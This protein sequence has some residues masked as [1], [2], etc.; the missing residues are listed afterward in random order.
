MFW[1]YTIQLWDWKSKK[2]LLLSL[3][4]FSVSA[5]NDQMIPESSFVQLLKVPVAMF[6]LLIES[7][8]YKHLHPTD[9]A[10]ILDF[11]DKIPAQTNTWS[12][13]VC[14]KTCRILKPL[15]KQM[16]CHLFNSVYQFGILLGPNTKT[17]NHVAVS[18]CLQL[19][20]SAVPFMAGLS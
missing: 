20:Q 5:L 10:K 3:Y 14:R 4:H 1:T 12:S 17:K 8:T 7:K 11:K 18:S 15:W 2:G 16:S 19:C 13:N 9:R 6:S